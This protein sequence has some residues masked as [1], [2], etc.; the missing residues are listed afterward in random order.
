MVS[1]VRRPRP[2]WVTAQGGQ[3]QKAITQGFSGFGQQGAIRWRDA[4]SL[5]FQRRL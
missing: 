2:P 4:R 1:T 3:Y 5:D